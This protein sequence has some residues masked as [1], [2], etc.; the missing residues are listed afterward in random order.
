MPRR[1]ASGHGSGS[2]EGVR[3]ASFSLIVM[4]GDEKSFTVMSAGF[5]FGYDLKEGGDYIIQRSN[6]IEEWN[7]KCTLMLKA[8]LA[9]A[10]I[11]RVA[12]TVFTSI[13]LRSIYAQT[14]CLS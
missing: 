8:S 3:A 7:F 12:E 14:R 1:R 9:I 6:S 4:V 5:T 2:S 11:V 10:S 13:F